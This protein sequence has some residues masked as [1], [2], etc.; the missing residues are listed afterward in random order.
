MSKIKITLDKKIESL[1]Q[2]EQKTLLK[3]LNSPKNHKKLYNHDFGSKHIRIGVISDTHIGHSKFDEK[4]FMKAVTFFNNEKVEAVYHVGDMLEGMSGREGHIYELCKIGFSEQIKY[5]EHLFNE[6]K[7]PVFGITGNHDQWYLK[8]NNAGVDVGE[9]LEKRVKD[10]TYLG[11]NEADITLNSKF[12]L[13]L[14]HANDGTAYATSYKLQKLMES[15][16]GGEKPHL[17]FEGH[18]HKAMYMFNR[19]IHGFESGT[20]MGQSEFMRL[21]KI[22]AHKGFWSVDLYFGNKSIERVKAEFLAKYD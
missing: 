5:A 8:K 7:V 13:K 9:E 3:Q 22:P 12:K 21:K 20:I 19:N 16:G 4:L 1:S 14:F 17:L 11:L 10:F 6:F 2:E 15:F 18:Y